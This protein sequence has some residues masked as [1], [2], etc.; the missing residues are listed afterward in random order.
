MQYGGSKQKHIYQAA[1][2]YLYKNRL[3]DI[4]ARIDVI[5]VYLHNRKIIIKS[6][7]ASSR[8]YIKWL[9]LIDEKSKWVYDIFS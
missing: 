8:T 9:K 7:K 3:D 6:H 4:F 1:E 2:Y 5:E